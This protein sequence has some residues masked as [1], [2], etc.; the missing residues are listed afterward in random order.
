MYIFIKIHVYIYTY[1]YRCVCLYALHY[2]LYIIYILSLTLSLTAQAPDLCVL[3]ELAE[4]SLSDLLYKGDHPPL[5]PP[6]M[7]AFA[8]IPYPQN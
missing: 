1:I 4:C 7:I 2:I 8:G 6:Q 3:T 5:R